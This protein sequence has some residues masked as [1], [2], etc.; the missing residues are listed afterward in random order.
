[1]EFDGLLGAIINNGV[2]VTVVVYFLLR[3]W[4]FHDKLESTLTTLINTVDALREAIKEC[5]ASKSK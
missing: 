1:M 3:D 2:A 5:V 4:Q